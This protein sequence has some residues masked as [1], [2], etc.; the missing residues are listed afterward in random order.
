MKQL[1]TVLL[2]FVSMGFGYDYKVTVSWDEMAM[3]GDAEG[4][5]QYMHDGETE[6]IRGNLRESS[7]DG[8]I[9]AASSLSG[10]IQEFII[11][12]SRDCQINLWIANNLMDESF[13]GK[14]D[15]LML[16]R[17][18]AKIEVTD[19]SSNQTVT[20]S[21]P[22]ETSGLIFH[23]GSIID[24][25]F[26]KVSE[27]YERQRLC[28]V[29]LLNAANGDPLPDVKVSLI[30]TATG[31]EVVTGRTNANGGFEHQLEYGRYTARFEKDEFIPSEHT[32]QMDLN[33]LPVFINAALTPRIK[34]L[35]IVLT[36]GAAP[37]DLD[38]H[39][40]GPDPAGGRFH[41]WW[42]NKAL[43]GGKNF[44]DVDDRQSYGPE[45]ITVY[46][47]AEGIYHY[48]VHNFS[49]RKRPNH[50][51]LSYSQ[52]R[53]DVYADGRHHSTVTIPVNRKG[54]TWHVFDFD[55]AGEIV[56]VNTFSGCVNS[57]KVTQ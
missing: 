21:I 24:G 10:G 47:P 4:V 19:Q 46:K 5:L 37:P 56:P 22:A 15:Y 36:W 25:V 13:A 52:S 7:N 20:V 44:L 26:Y 2:C 57:S 3:M 51:T 43:I 30:N 8:N 12:E 42:H 49:G 41:I 9:T 35:R 32:F 23:G 17:S 18:K 53:V 54:N 40:A 38:A 34:E 48:A 27:M 45:T 29:R 1:F 16:S 28:K 11:Q 39:L 14:E 31:Q 50:K 33:E 6:V 55:A